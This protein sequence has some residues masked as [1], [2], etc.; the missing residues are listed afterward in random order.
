MK[1]LLFVI[2]L[3]F[4]LISTL[5][6]ESRTSYVR[7]RFAYHLGSNKTNDFYKIGELKGSIDEQEINIVGYPNNL[8]S[9]YFCSHDEEEFEKGMLL[10]L[11]Y[12][13]KTQDLNS[14]IFST[15][16][17]EDYTVEIKQKVEGTSLI[18]AFTNGSYRQIEKNIY[19]IEKYGMP[20]QPFS[21]YP[22]LSCCI[23]MIFRDDKISLRG[24]ETFR[25][26]INRVCMEYSETTKENKPIIEV[27]KC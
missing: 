27:R 20:S 25:Y 8:S 14:I 16:Q 2:V 7:F 15:N 13:G 3:L 11:I 4:F 10:S 6:A 24:G 1:K 26:G 9:F 21:L 22:Q 23:A 12:S 18:L 17:A 5:K 19:T